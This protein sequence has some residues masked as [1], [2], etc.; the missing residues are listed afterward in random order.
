M[1]PTK[2]VRTPLTL[3]S[4]VPVIPKE[5]GERA[6]LEEDLTRIKCIGLM[7]KPWSVKDEKMVWELVTGA[8]NQYERTVRACLESWSVEKWREAYG[9]DVGGEGFASQTDKFIGRKFRNAANLKDG[10]AIANYE[11]SKAKRV[12]EFFI[13]ILYLEKPT[14][15]TVAVGNTIFGALLGKKKVDWGIVLQAIIAKLVEGAWKVKATPIG[16]YMFH[17]YM[18]HEVLSAEEMVAYDIGL[19]LLKY[20][21]TLESEPEPNQGS[22][23]WSD[24]QPS[25]SV[26]C[27]R[28]KRSNWPG[29]SQS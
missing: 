11:D 23:A 14:R 7:S 25:P 15:V 5:P 22:S 26:Q 8:L 16:P 19:D 10:F 28:R 20:D 2:T 27:N 6:Y 12:L 29:S 9:F 13:P 1:A 21:C 18:G 17:V 24:L 3:R 4:V